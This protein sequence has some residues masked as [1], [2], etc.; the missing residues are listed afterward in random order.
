MKSEQL[1]REFIQKYAYEWTER[2]YEGKPLILQQFIPDLNALLE[3][4]AEEKMKNMV[5]RLR[6]YGYHDCINEMLMWTKL[7][8][9]E[10][11]D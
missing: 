8:R 7:T 9:D 10:R 2:G 1:K 5:E 11:G 4:Y 6:M 3:A